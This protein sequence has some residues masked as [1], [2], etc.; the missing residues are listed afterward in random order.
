MN[1]QLDL[2]ADC[3]PETK[4]IFL[5][6]G[7]A[8]TCPK[9]HLCLRA[10]EDNH[11]LYFLLNGK[12][13]IYNL[14]KNGGRKILFVL[15]NGHLANESITQEYNSVFCETL[16]PCHLFKIQR[17]VFLTLM[18]QDFALART[19]LAYQ[20]QKIRRLEYQLKNTV[21]NVYLERKLASKLW[22]LAR[23]FGVPSQNGILIDMDLTVTFLADLLGA[24]RENTSRA[25][26]KL[27]GLGLIHMEKKKITIPDPEQLKLWNR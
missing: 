24:P 25:C 2:L 7:T 12:V 15:G 17:K 1:R 4:N 22:K 3:R 23:D 16:E 20:E 13:I 21:G 26:R 9:G 18:E 14:T 19:L 5:A 11:S 8:V 6:Q 27:C 10:G